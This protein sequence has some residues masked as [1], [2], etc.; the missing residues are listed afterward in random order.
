MNVPLPRLAAQPVCLRVNSP[1]RSTA[2]TVS[3][4]GFAMVLWPL[5]R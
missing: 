1:M 4:V 5:L 2:W 3:M